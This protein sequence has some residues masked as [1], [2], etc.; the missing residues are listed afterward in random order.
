[1]IALKL[2]LLLE[3]PSMEKWRKKL[4]SRVSGPYRYAGGEAFSRNKAWEGV[5]V[6]I[7]LAFPDLYEIGMS[8]L[9]LAILYGIVNDQNFALADRCFAPAADM[10]AGLKREGLPIFGIET[11]RAL[12]DFDIIGFSLAYELS[13]TNV[14][15]M[16]TLGGIPLSSCDRNNSHPIVIAGGPCAFNPMPVAKFFDAV[17]IGDGEDVIVEILKIVREFKGQR[18]LIL[19]KLS[20]I[21]GIYVPVKKRDAVGFARISDLNHASFPLPQVVPH[22][23]TQ[24]RL[25][26]EPSRGC[27]RGCRFCQAGYVYRP[28]RQRGQKLVSDAM[29]RAIC[30]S[31]AEE[32]SFLSLSIG[33]WAPFAGALGEIHRGLKDLPVDSSLPS[34]RVEALSEDV[35]KV[36]GRSRSGSFTLAPEAGTARMRAF[37][38]KGNTDEE[39]FAS[40]S[41]IFEMGW[42]A[43]KLYF[44]MGLPGETQEDIDGIIKTAFECLNIGRRFHKR[45]EITVSTSTFV[46][47]AHTPFQWDAQ[48]PIQRTKEIQSMF[49][50]GLR[51]PGLFYRWHL[52]EMSFLE[53]VFSRGGPELAGVI[54]GAYK[55]GARFDGWDEHFDFSRWDVAFKNADIDP[56]LYLEQ[57]S[58][59][60]QFPWDLLKTGPDR[61]FLLGER[62]RADELIATKDCTTGACTKCGMCDF[63]TVKNRIEVA[64]LDGASTQRR[65]EREVDASLD[66]QWHRLKYRKVGSAVF[67]GSIETL[68][69]LRRALRASGA[70]LAYSSGYH[71]RVC[72]SA[73]PA[74]SVGIES[75]AEFID[76]KM[77]NVDDDTFIK[78]INM[79]LPKGLEVV[80]EC[81]IAENSPPIDYAIK[82]SL[83]EI[84]FFS[85]NTR[86]FVSLPSN[87]VIEGGGLGWGGDS[88]NSPNSILFTRIR[89]DKKLEIDVKNYIGK[90]EIVGG[91]KIVIEIKNIKPAI[92]VVEVL[93]ALGLVTKDSHLDVNIKKVL[94]V[95]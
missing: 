42:H 41:K 17:V 74:L 12:A 92:K 28:L 75:E 45:P 53:G 94:V 88:L 43:V 93:Q 10:E 18:D 69:A 78:R 89:K 27:L 11:G 8:H 71:S 5:N 29:C 1:M 84:D 37:I 80:E 4:L 67:L 39:L 32:F 86:P 77:G 22:A 82:S 59:D 79:A 19:E 33:D 21:R 36:L 50:R 38:N 2:A 20:K 54:E 48:I 65:G 85:I 66:M 61:K 87:A 40:I 23:A 72:V 15:S 47:K 46:P 58:L 31:G 30:A 16:L 14:L 49:K 83:Y 62:E 7:C 13:Y 64:V 60:F 9:G 68:D 76:V 81:E 56:N 91:N 51:S 26:F 3:K 34:L 55:L 63:K 35:L 24:M 25:A 44:M 90:F 57:R 70:T 52:A 73:G 95:F 6:R